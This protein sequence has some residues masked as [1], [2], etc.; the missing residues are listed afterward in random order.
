MA[1][2]DVSMLFWSLFYL[3]VVLQIGLNRSQEVPLIGKKVIFRSPRSN[4]E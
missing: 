4:S 2:L 3:V 1:K